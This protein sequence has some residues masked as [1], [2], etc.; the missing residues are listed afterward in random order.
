MKYPVDN[1]W[2]GPYDVFPPCKFCRNVGCM[3]AAE[4]LIDIAP[5]CRCGWNPEVSRERIIR[6]YGIEATR[7][8][9]ELKRKKV[10]QKI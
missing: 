3:F 2:E 1:D 5:C 7:S 10:S 9:T 6:K 4:E 8:L